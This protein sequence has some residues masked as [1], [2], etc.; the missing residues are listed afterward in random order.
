MK[1]GAAATLLCIAAAALGGCGGDEETSTTT[2][3]TDS[4][5]PE[6]VPSGAVAIVAEAEDGTVTQEDFD[7]ALNRV[8]IGQ[9]VEEAPP[10]SDPEY[11]T[12]LDTAM[13]ELLNEIWIQ[14]E[15]AERGIELTETE[16]EQRTAQLVSQNFKDDQEFEDFAVE[17][18]LC[19]EE[20]LAAG[21]AVDC[22][23]VQD[24]VRAQLLAEAI[25]EEVFGAGDATGAAAQDQQEELA[26]E[27]EE[28]FTTT[29]RARTLCADDYTTAQCSN[30]PEP[31]AQ[32][33][34][35]LEE[36]IPPAAPAP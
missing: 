35:A 31:E 14:G 1:G 8:V 33:G 23:G 36:A 18:Q 2:S 13:A 5:A 11:Q 27:F 3:T 26:A 28:E 16:I 20:E 21:E 10:T 22:E 25:Q 6:S 30:G 9:G 12:Y 29:W 19:T 17:Q 7:A 32:P 15:A 4:P 24:R 34:G